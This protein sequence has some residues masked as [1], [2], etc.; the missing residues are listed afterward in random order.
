MSSKRYTS[1]YQQLYD[2]AY[3]AR[4]VYFRATPPSPSRCECLVSGTP[5]QTQNGLQA[6]ES[7]RTGDLVLTNEVESGALELRPV[8]KTTIRPPTDIMKIVTD[9]ETIQATLGHYWWVAGHGWLRTKELQ[10]GMRLHTATGTIQV[11]EVQ[12]TEEKLPTYNLVVDVTHTYF[13]G[14]NRVL[15]CD[16]TDVRATTTRVPGLSEPPIAAPNEK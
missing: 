16:A 4:G 8:I 15:S 5:I 13:V 1:E 11:N 10:E 3:Q 2:Q 7:I 6:V 9:N 14:K 12:M